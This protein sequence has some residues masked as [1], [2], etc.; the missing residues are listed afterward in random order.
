MEIGIEKRDMVSMK[1][2]GKRETPEGIEPPSQEI[3]WKLGEKE[4]NKCQAML[5]GNITKQWWK[6]K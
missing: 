3:I 1:K 6:E 4:N 5:E 2:K